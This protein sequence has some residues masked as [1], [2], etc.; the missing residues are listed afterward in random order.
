M[1]LFPVL[2][3]CTIKYIFD[4]CMNNEGHL[5]NKKKLKNAF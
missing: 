4:F 1:T 5:N 3:E 2:F